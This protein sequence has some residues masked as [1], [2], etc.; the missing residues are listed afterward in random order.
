ME[1]KS[2]GGCPLRRVMRIM[3]G[4]WKPYILCVLSGK[5]MRFNE[6][7]RTCPGITQAMLTKQLRELEDDGFVTRKVYPE[8]PPKVEYSLTELGVSFL[9][10]LAHMA[11]WGQDHP[12]K[13]KLS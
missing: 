7:Y 4:K 10:V 5:T 12:M 3:G 9:P 11:E 2:D 1:S 8:V 6:I 13:E